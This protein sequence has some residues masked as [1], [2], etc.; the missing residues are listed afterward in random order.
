M[1]LAEVGAFSGKDIVPGLF[2]V[3]Y[4]SQLGDSM[5]TDAAGNGGECFLGKVPVMDESA[6][7][8]CGRADCKIIE[9][10][11]LVAFSPKLALWYIEAFTD[12]AG[13][14]ESPRLQKV[15]FDAGREVHALIGIV[16]T[17]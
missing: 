14:H 15:E 10:P 7:P 11:G 3:L 12:L 16:T 2:P 13:R 1:H 8:L 6:L 5:L 4:F 17:P 9:H